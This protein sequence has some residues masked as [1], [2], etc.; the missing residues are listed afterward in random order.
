MQHECD[1]QT[2]R[3]TDGGI[4]AIT[5]RSILTA[6]DFVGIIATVAPVITD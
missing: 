5:T 6:I 1:R 4:A 3:Q 2:D